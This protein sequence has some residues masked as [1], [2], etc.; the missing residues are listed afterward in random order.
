MNNYSHLFFFVVA[1]EC[2]E[3]WR[4]LQSTFVKN[5]KPKPS[6]SGTTKKKPYYLMEAMQFAI[7]FVKVTGTST[8]NLPEI[9]QQGSTLS[10][11]P[12]VSDMDV[13][14][15]ESL[16]SEDM[17][18][19]RQVS[20]P[21]NRPPLASPGH[22]VTP[23][24]DTATRVRGP[25]G[26]VTRK[27]KLTNVSSDADRAFAQ[28]FS[29]KTAK[30]SNPP[31][32]NDRREDEVTQTPQ[33]ILYYFGTNMV[34]PFYRETT[35]NISNP[36]QFPPPLQYPTESIIFVVTG[37]SSSESAQSTYHPENPLS[38]ENSS[39]TFQLL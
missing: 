27:R 25:R 21:T 23:C 31:P 9:P 5:L 16:F 38:P 17:S 24:D 3:K 15:E 32:A 29:A 6:G 34:P 4:N 13:T 12:E 10:I 8:G 18:E 36:N 30:L 1:G 7:P 37:P 39:R 35:R 2:K 26:Q 28:Y 11:P 14:Y 20:I 19:P 22:N 33:E